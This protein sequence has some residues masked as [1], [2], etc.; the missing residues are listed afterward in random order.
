M[1]IKGQAARCVSESYTPFFVYTHTVKRYV[2]AKLYARYDRDGF[3]EPVNL[4]YFFVG[5]EKIKRYYVKRSTNDHRHCRHR[6]TPLKRR[7]D[8]I[9]MDHNFIRVSP[10]RFA[11][12]APVTMVC[13]AVQK[14]RDVTEEKDC[15]D[16]RYFKYSL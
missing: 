8:Q 9:E 14:R 15:D 1:K 7:R 3:A 10:R 5:P 4:F 13:S 12:A 6:Q 11:R 16:L 2:R